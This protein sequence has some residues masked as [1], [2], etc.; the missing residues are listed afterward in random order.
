MTRWDKNEMLSIYP[1]VSR[2]YTLRCSFHLCYPCISVHPLSLL[3]NLLG[4]RD[5]ASLEMHLEAEM[6]WTQRCTWRLWLSEFG[7]AL[8]G[9]D[10]VNTKMPSEAVTELHWRCTCRLRSSKI[11]GVLGGGWFGGRR[12]G[13]LDSIHRLTCNC[14][15]VESWVHHPPRD[16]KLA[17][18]G[19]LLILG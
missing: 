1:R 6:E 11:G 15:N 8:G 12:D 16:E 2:I 5:W 4:C 9:R 7:H 13:S 17:G 14:G 18:S 19:R 3:N 10:Q